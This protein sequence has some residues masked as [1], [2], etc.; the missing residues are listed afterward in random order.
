MGDHELTKN[1]FTFGKYK[2]SSVTTVIRDRSYCEWLMDQDWFQTNYEYLYNC[3]QQ[4]NPLDYFIPPTLPEQGMFLE[5]YPYFHLNTLDHVN[6]PLTVSEQECYTFYIS[7][8]NELKQKIYTRL[9]QEEENPYDIKAPSGWL[10]RFEKECGIPRA[11]FKE[12]LATYDLP[13]ITYIVE[14]IKKE[15]GLVY[16]GARS[17]I[18]AKSRSVAQEKWWEDILKARYGENIGTQF[19]YGNCIFDFINIST[20]TVFE[21]KLGMK[22]FVHDQ[23]VKYKAMMGARYRVIYLIGYDAVIDMEKM[24]I[25]TTQPDYYILYRDG[26][27]YMKT[28][29]YLDELIQEFSVTYVPVLDTLFNV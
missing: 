12:F 24:Q 13:N 14:H 6:L 8:I 2:G 25:Y 17:F 15:G 21:C 19:K 10:K 3:I 1:T 7:L 23:Y 29:S 18:I 22:D 27:P 5:V 9:E 4:F 16:N 11:D 26:I 20:H 28:P